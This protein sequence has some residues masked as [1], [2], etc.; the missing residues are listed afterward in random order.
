MFFL[1]GGT[2][3]AFDGEF[4]FKINLSGCLLQSFNKYEAQ[5]TN[6]CTVRSGRLPQRG[7]IRAWPVAGKG[8]G[9]LVGCSGHHRTGHSGIIQALRSLA[10]YI[11]GLALLLTRVSGEHVQ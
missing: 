6:S 9:R 8:Q 1:V 7:L 2:P 3:H 4:S 5:C 10:F 11:H